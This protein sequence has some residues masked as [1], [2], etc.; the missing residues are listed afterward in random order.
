MFR[1][2]NCSGTGK[3]KLFRKKYVPRKNSKKSCRKNKNKMFQE[4]EKKKKAS[5]PPPPRLLRHAPLRLLCARR[6][7]WAPRASSAGRGRR[8]CWKAAR[9]KNSCR[10]ICLLARIS[11]LSGMKLGGGR[12]TGRIPVWKQANRPIPYHSPVQCYSGHSAYSYPSSFSPCTTPNSKSSP[13]NVL[14]LYPRQRILLPML[15]A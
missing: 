10:P 7:G 2:K 11:K 4:K 12:P 9:K 13:V 8:R 6:R 14:G 5:P 1:K 15:E 3:Q